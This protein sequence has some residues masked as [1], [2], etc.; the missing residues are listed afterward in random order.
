MW[1]WVFQMMFGSPP[2][3]AS[4]RLEAWKELAASK[5]STPSWL[6]KK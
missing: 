3:T 6:Q 4:T 2:F 1:E 5:A